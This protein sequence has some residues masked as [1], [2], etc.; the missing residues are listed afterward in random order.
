[1]FITRG[2]STSGDSCEVGIYGWLE[3][4]RALVLLAEG[5]RSDNMPLQTESN[6]AD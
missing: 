3:T 5:V 6:V 4:S 1:M 2:V